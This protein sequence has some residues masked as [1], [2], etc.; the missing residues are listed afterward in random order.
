MHESINEHSTE[1]SNKFTKIDKN[2]KFSVEKT[3]FDKYVASLNSK[4]HGSDF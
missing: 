3:D 4:I 2:L 1:N